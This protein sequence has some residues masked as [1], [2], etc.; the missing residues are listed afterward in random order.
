MKSGLYPRPEGLGFTPSGIKP[1]WKWEDLRLDV[2]R[3]YALSTDPHVN[4]KPI[5]AT[6]LTKTLQGIYEKILRNEVR[7]DSSAATSE[8]YISL[9]MRSVSA[10]RE[11]WKFLREELQRK[12]P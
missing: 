10:S 11:K 9:R 4:I 8:N 12:S 1:H 6:R 7:F 2:E 3:R 5:V